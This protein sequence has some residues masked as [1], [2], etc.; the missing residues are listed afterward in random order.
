M[1]DEADASRDTALL[2]VV[3]HPIPQLL[4]LLRNETRSSPQM[5]KIAKEIREGRAAP[6]LT[7]VD[8]LVYYGRRIFVGSRS[9]AQMPILTEYHSSQSAG[10][11]GFERMLHRVSAGF[12]WPSMKKDVKKFIEACVVC[13]TT[14]QVLDPE[15]GRLAAT[16]V[17]PNSGMGGC[18]HGFH[19]RP[20]AVKVVYNDH[21]RS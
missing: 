19:H 6:H 16:V 2:S 5:R 20:S 13:Q 14:Y 12:Y 17:N 1:E 18:V 11:P 21:G 15:T 3:A 4:E 8:G 10:H 7:L 9:S